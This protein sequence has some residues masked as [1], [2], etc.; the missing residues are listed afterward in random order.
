MFRQIFEREASLDYV[1]VELIGFAG[2]GFMLFPY[3][4]NDE[5]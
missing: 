5:P 3:V 1:Q 2:A 4:T